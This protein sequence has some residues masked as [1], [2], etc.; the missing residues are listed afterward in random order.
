LHGEP[1]LDQFFTWRPL[2]GSAGYRVAGIDGLYLCSSGSHPGGG[3]TAAPG[4]NAAREIL[5]RARQAE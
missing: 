1:G 5:R 4:A 3:I 2:L